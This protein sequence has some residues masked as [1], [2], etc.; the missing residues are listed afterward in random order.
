MSKLLIKG[1]RI[2]DVPRKLGMSLHSDYTFHNDKVE[3]GILEMLVLMRG[4]CELENVRG[5]RLWTRF[6]LKF[7][8]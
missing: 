1:Q 7:F 2:G 6:H 8:S 5:N 3:T 4:S